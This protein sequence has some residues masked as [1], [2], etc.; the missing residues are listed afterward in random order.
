MHSR[1]N[2]KCAQPYLTYA[3]PAASFSCRTDQVAGTH[4]LFQRSITKTQALNKHARRLPAL[5]PSARKHREVIEPDQL[6]WTPRPPQLNLS[7]CS[8]VHVLVL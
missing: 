5:P 8:S 1:F 3:R 4:L 7:L 6:F 2:S